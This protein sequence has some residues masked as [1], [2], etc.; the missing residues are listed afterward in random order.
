MYC[1]N[2]YYQIKCTQFRHSNYTMQNCILTI[3][4]SSGY[5]GRTLEEFNAGHVEDAI[6]VPY[7]FKVGEGILTCYKIL[8]LPYMSF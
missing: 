8:R 6:N 3:E 7:M 1:L 4:F 2:L 5:A